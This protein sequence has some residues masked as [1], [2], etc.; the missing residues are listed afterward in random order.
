MDRRQIAS[1]TVSNPTRRRRFGGR[2][3][4]A[5][6][7][8][9]L[10]LPIAVLILGLAAT[11]GQM[12]AESI[13]LT[14]AARSAALAAANDYAAG[15]FSDEVHDATVAAQDEQ[16]GSAFTC[17]GHNCVSVN[18]LSGVNYPG[19]TMAVVVITQ[20]IDPFIPIVPQITVTGTATAQGDV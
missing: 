3:G 4:Q 7:E 2:A 18:N 15:N 8:F 9:A 19:Q 12:L 6:T 11:G 16:G 10:V 1:A 17:P 5:V 13:T 14:Q 20:S